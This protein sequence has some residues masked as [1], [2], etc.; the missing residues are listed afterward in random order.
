MARAVGCDESETGWRWTRRPSATW[1]GTYRAEQYRPRA[2]ASGAVS[3]CSSPGATRAA[4][5]AASRACTA[6]TARD[7]RRP[8]R[9]GRMELEV[10][11]RADADVGR[12]GRTERHL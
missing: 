5:R 12:P 2:L 4:G 6:P 3:A 9:T 1:P 7:G 11:V 8:R 10:V